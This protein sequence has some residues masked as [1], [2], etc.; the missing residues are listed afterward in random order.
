MNCFKTRESTE[1]P[2][3]CGECPLPCLHFQVK[4]WCLC[5]HALHIALFQDPSQACQ[6]QLKAGEEPGHCT[7]TYG[8]TTYTLPHTYRVVKVKP[9]WIVNCLS[10]LWFDWVLNESSKETKTKMGVWLCWGPE[11]NSNLP[12]LPCWSREGM[13]HSERWVWVEA[14]LSEY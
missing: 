7:L 13:R 12:S 5:K 14:W 1:L 10:V 2:K 3:L 9:Y 11:W 6:L 4:T 8:H